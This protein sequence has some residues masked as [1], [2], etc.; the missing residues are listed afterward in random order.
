MDETRKFFD[1]HHELLN[2]QTDQAEVPLTFAATTKAHGSYETTR[3]VLRLSPKNH[4]WM[5]KIEANAFDNGPLPWDAIQAYST[6][7]HETVHWWQHV[8]STSGLLLSL[9]YFSQCHSS[10]QELQECL[11]KFGPI[12]P[13]KR[14][15]D[16]VLLS[17]GWDAQEKLAP[18]NVA[19]NNA[20]D[21]FYYK[22]YALRPRENIKWMV[23]QIHFEDV[24]YTYSIVY[25]MVIALLSDA[26]DPDFKF[27]QSIRELNEEV[28]RLH[29]ED[30]EGFTKGSNIHL[31]YV[32]LH[33]IYE[34]QARFI[35]LDFLNRCRSEPLTC[36][37]WRTEGY[38]SGIYVEAFESFLSLTETSWPLTLFDPIVPLFLLVCDLSINPTRGI[39]FKVGPFENL[40]HQVDVGTRFAEFCFAIKAA[41]HL[42]TAINDLSFEE[43]AEVS[44][45][46]CKARGY[47]HPMAALEEVVRWVDEYPSVQQL[48]EEH[49]TFD[50]KMQNMNVRV[51]LSHYIAMCIDKYD[52][53]HFF[54]WPGAYMAGHP[55]NIDVRSIWLRHL[56]L[57]SDKAE[58]DGVYPRKQP[59]RLDSLVKKT[60]D[61]FYGTMAVYE[62]TEQWILR[63]GPFNCD[64]SWMSDNYDEKIFGDWANDSFKKVFGVELSDFTIVKAEP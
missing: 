50:F 51:F 48:M 29:K 38:L 52:N 1:L 33:A 5:D 8:G 60:F 15:T 3:F 37:E 35:Q 56:S 6:Y 21:V 47:D 63:E 42:K 23:N 53:P 40:I 12:K 22:S 16:Q 61:S 64:F 39:P 7:M 58:K 24:G 43:Y 31:P 30:Y 10:I 62:L 41:P 57:F 32:G 44:A 14:W 20:L 13:L 27:L 45:E 46:L 34:G 26:I 11:E 55:S 25:G 19:V 18:A 17:E 28:L 2:P 49:R 9:S 4:E 36:E 54:C 59:G